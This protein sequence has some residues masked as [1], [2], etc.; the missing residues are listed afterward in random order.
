MPIHERLK[1]SR[2]KLKYSQKE[3]AEKIGVSQSTMQRYEHGK[4]N[5]NVETLKKICDLTNEDPSWMI[6]GEIKE[7]NLNVKLAQLAN[8]LEKEE[9]KTIEEIINMAELIMMKNQAKR[10]VM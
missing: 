3:M 10:I 4:E 1:I 9:E 5:M 7:K 8:K 6:Y 2:V